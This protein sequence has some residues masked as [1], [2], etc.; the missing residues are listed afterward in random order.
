MKGLVAHATLVPN[1][2]EMLAEDGFTVD[3]TGF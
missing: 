3:N 1:T 2:L